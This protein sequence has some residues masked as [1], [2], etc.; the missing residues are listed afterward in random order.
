MRNNNHDPNFVDPAAEAAE[1]IDD[2][3]RVLMGL[4]AGSL[5]GVLFGLPP[6]AAQA[7][8]GIGIVG[9]AQA[10]PAAPSAAAIAPWWPSK[11]GKD[12]QIGATNLVTPAKILDALKLVKTGKVTPSR[13][14]SWAATLPP[15]H[16][17][18]PI[19][20]LDR[21]NGLA[22]ETTLA[23]KAPCL[24]ATTANVDIMKA[25]GFVASRRPRWPSM[26]GWQAL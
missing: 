11:W 10:Q 18:V 23:I 6:T 8:G 3:R 17:G 24:V 7:A 9:A 16:P 15:S 2:D 19:A 26:A 25:A 13:G 1:G 14:F 12:D 5:A 4:A 21:I 22:S 20:T